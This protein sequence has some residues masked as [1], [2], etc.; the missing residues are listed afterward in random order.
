LQILKATK[1][2][3]VSVG[4]LGCLGQVAT[5]NLVRG[6]AG[7]CLFCYARCISGA[8]EAGKLL[9]YLDLPEQLE[10]QLER[11][12]R[13]PP[14]YVLLSTASDPFLGGE[15]ILD[16]TRSCLEILIRRRIG[17]SLSTRGNIPD[18]IIDMLALHVPFVRVTIPLVSLSDDYSTTWE[19]GTIRPRQ[20]LFLVQ[21]LLKAG[22]RTRIRLEPIIPYVSDTT[23]QLRELCSAIA[24]LG[25]TRA[26]VSFLHL[27]PGV[28]EQIQREAPPDISHLILGSFALP[29][30][31]QSTSMKFFHLPVKQRVASLRRIQ[32]IG[33]ERGIGISACH[34]QNPGIPARACPVL[35][36][37]LPQPRGEQM[38]LIE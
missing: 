9:A 19:P 6:C 13:P 11:R 3:A 8:P 16:L 7:Q 31:T 2:H 25:L 34:C 1:K 4:H 22:I 33:R 21:K 35:P 24:S 28:A 38:S 17:V 26:Q 30:P 23:E 32:R 5:I 29:P 27:R 37:E 14:P 12:R 18:D 36:P 10:Q 20:R 15:Q